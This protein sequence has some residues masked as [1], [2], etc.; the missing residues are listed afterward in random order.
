MQGIE[1]GLGILLAI[2]VSCLIFSSIR[3]ILKP[4]NKKTSHKINRLLSK[5][6]IFDDW[7]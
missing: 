5:N 4:L 3:F 2:F 6:I 7:K 1:W